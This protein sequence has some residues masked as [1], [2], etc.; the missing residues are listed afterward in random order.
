M[1]LTIIGTVAFDGIETPKGSYPKILGGSAMYAATAASIFSPVNIV[2]IVGQ[3]FDQEYFDYF[4]NRKI[5]IDGITITKNNNTF[6][7][8]GFYEKD[9]NQAFTKQTQLNCLL[10]FNPIIPEK[11]KNSRIVFLANVD[12]VL[13]KKA[14][15]QFTKPDLVIL[16][17]M[18]Y[19]IEHKLK[20]L[21]ETINLVDI[22]ILND[23]EIKLLTRKDNLILAMKELFQQN[24][25]KLLVVKK[26]EHGAIMYDGNTFFSLPAIP[27]DDITDPTGAGDSFAGGFAGYLASAQHIDINAFKRAIIVGTLISSFTVQGFGVSKL[28]T[29]A[30]QDLIDQF[31]KLKDITTLSQD[32]F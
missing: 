21:L 17:T 8:Q 25:L 23:Q 28:Q 3:D 26:G 22:L 5:N 7:W 4:I 16:D 6:Y 30:K 27:L 11:A 31:L 18:N 10:E 29:I 19:W 2:S 32:I 15:N 14:I 24:K 1:S 9:M 20:D 12:P 13:Q